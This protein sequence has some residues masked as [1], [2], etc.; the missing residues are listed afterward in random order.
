MAWIIQNNELTNTDFV[1]APSRPFHG[2]SPTIFWRINANINDGLPR[3]GLMISQVLLG[4]FAD[5]KELEQ[6]SIPQSVKYI[7]RYAFR[8]TKIRSATIASDCTYYSTSFP[9]G[10]VVNFYPD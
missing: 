5:A 8:N 7:G 4:A 2:D 9:N 1:N 3:I 10:C 6:V